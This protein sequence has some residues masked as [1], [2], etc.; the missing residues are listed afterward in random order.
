MTLV[1]KA[2][3]IDQQSNVFFIFMSFL[4]MEIAEF[5]LYVLI[6]VV[7]THAEQNGG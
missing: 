3:N 6:Q 5:V 7:P 2:L 1:D 4:I